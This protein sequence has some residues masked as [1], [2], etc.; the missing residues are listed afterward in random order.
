MKMDNV[1]HIGIIGTGMMASSMAVLTTGHGYRTTILARSSQ[2]AESCRGE[3]ETFYK[4]IVDKTL[5]ILKDIDEKNLK[6]EELLKKDNLKAAWHEKREWLLKDK[7]D[8]TE[9]MVDKILSVGHTP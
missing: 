1:K 8:V 2:R 6:I 7:I 3:V 4:E 9:F 5:S